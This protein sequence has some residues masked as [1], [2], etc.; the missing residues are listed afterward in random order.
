MIVRRVPI[1]APEDSQMSSTTHPAASDGLLPASEETPVRTG[2]VLVAIG[3]EGNAPV[4]RA[5]ELVAGALGRT[6]RMASAME[7]L[8]VTPASPP[9]ESSSFL[10]E[11]VASERR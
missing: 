11:W 9:H 8:P 7:S 6:G 1:P 2:P 5:G 3:D 4:L 10:P